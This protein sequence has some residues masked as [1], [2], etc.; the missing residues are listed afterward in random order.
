MSTAIDA[1]GNELDDD[2]VAKLMS[3]PATSVPVPPVDIQ[4]VL[5][6]EKKNIHALTEQINLRNKQFINE[7]SVKIERWADDQTS[8]LEQELKDLKKQ[9]KEK[10]RV[11]R[12]E[13]DDGKR[14]SL[15]KEIQSIQK[16]KDRSVRNFLL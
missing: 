2:F 6:L 4:P 8:L 3:I 13:A 5:P 16:C 12:A 7:E 15:Q 14:L 1:E 11:F 9:I 10:E